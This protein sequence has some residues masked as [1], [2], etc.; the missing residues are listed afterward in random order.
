MLYAWML[1]ENADYLVQ[2]LYKILLMQIDRTQG[3]KDEKILKQIRFLRSVM[4]CS[5]IVQ[6]MS[7]D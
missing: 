2:L 1:D 7:K 3:S 5:L 4:C 6:S